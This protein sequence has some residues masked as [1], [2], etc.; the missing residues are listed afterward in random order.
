MSEMTRDDRGGDEGPSL[1]YA[2][3]VDV[4][5]IECLEAALVEAQ[6]ARRQNLRLWIFFGIYGALLAIVVMIGNHLSV[7]SVALLATVG[8]VYGVF[9][10]MFFTRRSRLYEGHSHLEVSAALVGQILAAVYAGEQREAEIAASGE[11]AEKGMAEEAIEEAADVGPV[12]TEVGSE[13]PDLDSALRES[14]KIAHA[15]DSRV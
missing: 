3:A 12:T 15:A 2:G 13:T 9:E 1:V 7:R 11:S 14:E 10:G 4:R 5:Q 6:I 8:A